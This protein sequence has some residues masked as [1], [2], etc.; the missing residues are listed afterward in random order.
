MT[1]KPRVDNVLTR[2]LTLASLSLCLAGCATHQLPPPG[3]VP[4]PLVDALM[5]DRGGM[6][7]AAPDISIGVLPA[8][9]PGALIPDGPVHV[10]GGMKNAGEITAIFADSTRRLAA[11]FEQLFAQRGFTRPETQRAS[12]FRAGFGAATY[13]CNDSAMVSAAP[14]G[15]AERNFARV[16]YRVSHGPQTCGAYGS[17]PVPIDEDTL[18]LPALTA[19]PGVRVRGTGGGGGSS[20]INSNAEM[21]GQGIV[22]ADVLAHYTSQLVA[23][24]WT[25]AGAPAIGG[26]VAAQ[27]F[28]AKGSKGVRWHGVLMIAGDATAIQLTLNMSSR[29]IQ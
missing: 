7:G 10:V 27:F 2:L 22:L 1:M 21:T 25:A 14:L 15:G 9:F 11:V 5:T 6:P 17:R 3:M 18:A 29:P 26:R 20:G 28:E 16:T 24:G 19:P 4:T 23:A 12:G 13:F 8:G